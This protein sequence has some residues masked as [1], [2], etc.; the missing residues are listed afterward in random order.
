MTY[1]VATDLRTPDDLPPVA[2]CNHDDPRNFGGSGFMW[3]PGIWDGV[4]M[5]PKHCPDWPE[6]Y[7]EVTRVRSLL[8]KV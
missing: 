3:R 1:Y 2:A 7:A 5:N 4:S 8:R 6:I